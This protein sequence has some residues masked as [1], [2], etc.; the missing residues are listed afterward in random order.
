MSQY[1]AN[2]MQAAAFLRH[3][4]APQAPGAICQ[5]S[6]SFGEA[7]DPDRLRQAW[8]V[9]FD[10][11]P[12][13]RSAFIRTGTGVM[14]REAAKGE[15]DWIALD[16]CSISQEEIPAKWNELLVRDAG[17]EF[18][19]LSVPLMRWHAIQLP[20]GA[21]H[22]L[23]SMPSYLIDGFSTTRILI[24][25]LLVLGDAVPAPAGE[26]PVP[27][28]AKGWETFLE[29]ATLPQTLAP[30]LGDGSAA[31]ATLLLNRDKTAEFSAFCLKHD[32]EESLV[33]RCLFALL[34]RR[35]G[36]KGN[37]MKALFDARGESAE[38]GYFLNW[39]PVAHKWKG[40][41][42]EW[43]SAAQEQTD[44][45][46]EQ[47]W[48]EPDAVMRAAGL[49]FFSADISV[50]YAWRTGTINNVIH[51]ALPRW[52]NFDAQPR[53]V[54]S[55]GVFLEAKP[56]PR[57]E[58]TLSGP[59]STEA[60]V[61]DVL[62][63]LGGLIEGISGIYNKPVDRMPVLQPDE[64]RIL[65]DWTRGPVV[66]ATP[67]S[68][69]EVFRTVV[70][71]HAERVAI[72]CGDY[73]MTYAEL[74]ELS[75]KMAAH[76]THAGF[77]GGWHTGLAM[78]PS[79]WV[80]VALLGAWKAGNSCIAIDPEADAGWIERVLAA[81]DVAV[82]VCDA[83]SAEGVD[84]SQR[85]CIVIDKDW[86]TLELAML[87][88]R[89]VKAEQLAATLP[90][91][92]GDTPPILAALTH[93]TMV[94]AAL[95]GARVMDFKS[96]ESFLVRAVPGG[97]AFFDEWLIPLLTGGTA[98]IAL[99]KLDGPA[100]FPVTHL[101]LTTPEWANQAAAWLSG[102]APA[103]NSLRVV[104]IEAGTPS[105]I[106]RTVWHTRLHP[107]LHQVVFSSP[108]GLVGMGLAGVARKD[109]PVLTVGKPTGDVQISL[110]DEDGMEVL[111]GFAGAVHMKFP[112]WKNLAGTSGR[113]GVD[114]GLLGWRDKDGDVSLE[115]AEQVCTGVPGAAERLARAPFLPH[116]LDAV[117]ADKMYVLSTDEV[118]GAVRV[119]EW[120]LN[121]GGWVDV[122][123]LLGGGEPLDASPSE[124]GY[125][126]AAPRMAPAH[127]PPPPRRP[128]AETWS[129]V[130]K[131]QPGQG[132]DLLVLVPPASGDP[133]DYAE[134]VK[135]LGP[136]R[137]VIGIE[138]RAVLNPELSHPSIESAAAQYIAALFEEERPVKY[139][140]A[141]FGFGGAVVLEM[142][143][144][145]AAAGR[146]V[147]RLVLFGSTPPR[148]E[149]P[150]GWLHTVKKALKKKPAPL[151]M[152]PAEPIG[153][154]ERRHHEL[155]MAYRAES[156]DFPAT[157]VLASDM[158]PTT[159]A[160]WAEVLPEAD[161]EVT[162]SPWACMLDYPGV[163]RVASILNSTT[164]VPDDSNSFA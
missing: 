50:G 159:A 34:L 23:M 44:A 60:A 127:Q 38:A 140:L 161:V 2:P 61:K 52:I 3:D 47:I 102:S 81:H 64:I 141:G 135:A 116:A 118:P 8:R 101:R 10:R 32:L 30:R 31:R 53:Q 24:D 88:A 22:H 36:A 124:Q 20:G 115:S 59:F 40:T 13:L 46:D 110:T 68:L 89:E 37:V 87:E 128:T 148:H 137:P 91:H 146:P 6:I 129:P 79:A 28:K 117:V 11:H 7:I 108:A 164:A 149:S 82:V 125:Q 9:V 163:K 121:R 58:L 42:R 18:E 16:W 99:D 84:Q 14:V 107:P 17:N 160:E 75:D 111:P 142:A 56:G 158:E 86:D 100:T 106:A 97:G 114:L 145:L 66:P 27:S 45:M 54:D 5:W 65:R 19:A 72:R 113:L 21:W 156:L 147:P 136:E 143:R 29:G 83:Q 35:L 139:Q 119:N 48:I 39:L 74:D 105:Q 162:K 67:A 144:Q 94:A 103:A 51:T 93:G 15:P 90:G 134:L 63:R 26:M 152:E 85:R 33:I 55:G 41:V 92:M 62:S 76:L 155:W 154:I 1:P 49:D 95:E 70:E 109:L 112:G 122:A 123:A 153:D 150:R 69:V 104:A 77:A 133:A 157:V 12:I 131:M 25:L 126:P 73:E 151:R 57:L 98:F 80:G 71:A 130:V 4:A 132:G 43:L 138:A 78:S 96:G 120:P